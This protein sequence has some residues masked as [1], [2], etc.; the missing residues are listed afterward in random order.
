[1]H[2]GRQTSSKSFSSLGI[3]NNSSTKKNQSNQLDYELIKPRPEGFNQNCPQ[4]NAYDCLVFLIYCFEH[5]KFAITYIDG[6]TIGLPFV[7]RDGRNWEK[8]TKE[9]MLILFEIRDPDGTMI[10]P[11]NM[12][13]TSKSIELF[14]VQTSSNR[15]VN[16]MTQ[17][18]TITKCGN[19]CEPV[20]NI[21]WIKAAKILEEDSQNII[22]GPEFRDYFQYLNQKPKLQVIEK[23]LDYIMHYVNHTENVQDVMSSFYHSH[24][25]AAKLVCDLYDDYLGRIFPSYYFTLPSFRNFMFKCGLRSTPSSAEVIKSLYNCCLVRPKRLTKAKHLDFHDICYVVISMDPETPNNK[26]RLQ[27]LFSFYNRNNDGTLSSDEIQ[28]MFADLGRKD[29]PFRKLT[30]NEFVK[31]VNEDK[32]P[33]TQTLCRLDKSIINKFQMK[34]KVKHGQAKNTAIKSSINRGVCQSCRAKNYEYG[35]HCVLF[36]TMYHCVEPKVILNC[37][38]RQLRNEHFLKTNLRWHFCL[39]A[40]NPFVQPKLVGKS[41]YSADY[42]F[43][44][45][46]IGNVLFDYIRNKKFLTQQNDDIKLQENFCKFLINLT[47]NIRQLVKH[48]QKLIK[49]NAPA[50]VVGDLQG[51]LDNIF[52]ME[53]QFWSTMPVIPE[54]LIFLGNYTG[55]SN[56]SIEVLIY[57]MSIKYM[58][59]NQV[60]LLRGIQETRNYNEKTLLLECKLRYGEEMGKQLWESFNSVFDHLPYVAIINESIVCTSSGIPKDAIKYKLSTLFENYTQIDMKSKTREFSIFQQVMAN[61]PEAVDHENSSRCRT[62]KADSKDREVL[63]KQNPLMPNAYVYTREAFRQFM[64]LNQFTYMI[65]SN[66]F[67]QDGHRIMY[68][69][70]L[71][72]V[73][74]NSNFDD[75]KNAAVVVFIS[76]QDSKIQLIQIDTECRTTFSQASSTSSIG[77]FQ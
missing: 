21:N 51:S 43:K 18:V 49:C 73:F 52:T 61:M 60:Y 66:E 25:I 31:A 37:K 68:N 67:V 72:T 30:F 12:K 74:S 34:Q 17:F 50:I 47:D 71:I 38:C 76:H 56:Y 55:K 32:I 5:D 70:R 26:S 3:G 28:N 59:P 24:S 57:L 8:V 27:F 63:F 14:R 22:W 36:D 6:N 33:S 41:L 4:S 19:N 10:R 15:W 65:R 48:E 42:V 45:T 40:E 13:Y 75:N 7:I 44:T 53:S 11:M 77:S 2:A 64:S 29:V 39:S 35:Q 23:P 20:N 69:N 58:S 9:G 54:N 46:S 1:M 62:G 16:R